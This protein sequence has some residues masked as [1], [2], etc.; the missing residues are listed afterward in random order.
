VDEFNRGF[1]AVD[2]ASMRA[3]L[4]TTWPG[5][6]KVLIISDEHDQGIGPGTLMR[7]RRIGQRGTETVF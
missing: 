1:V 6:W 5:V 3:G 7:Q 2:L 4:L